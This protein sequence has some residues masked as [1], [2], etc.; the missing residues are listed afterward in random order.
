MGLIGAVEGIEV[1]FEEPTNGKDRRF[2]C[3]DVT[4][5]VVD[6]G[7]IGTELEETA[8]DGVVASTT[9]EFTSSSGLPGF[10]TNADPLLL[11]H[12]LLPNCNLRE[13][14]LPL[15]A[16]A[17]ASFFSFTSPPL[18]ASSS[19]TGGSSV[20]N[21]EGVGGA[22][23]VMLAIVP[24]SLES[25]TSE[26]VLVNVAALRFMNQLFL[27]LLPLEAAGTEERVV[28]A[29]TTTPIS[30][31]S[32]SSSS[33]GGA[34]VAIVGVLSPTI[35]SLLFPVPLLMLP[36][37]EDLV[38]S[39]LNVT[40]RCIPGSGGDE[41]S[42][43]EVLPTSERSLGESTWRSPMLGEDVELAGA[44]ESLRFREP[45][46][47]LSE[48]DR[49]TVSGALA[50]ILGK[51]RVTNTAKTLYLKKRKHKVSKKEEKKTG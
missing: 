35:S 16:A 6:G 19:E 34:K 40:C 28:A 49:A 22:E 25:S 1:V 44:G 11:F 13:I 31:T 15:F 2:C 5:F 27:F 3:L 46:M 14:R 18:P 42:P 30:E 48:D 9:S 23:L 29:L 45:A 12:D 51:T 32:F 33:S 37:A 43:V 39:K 50:A 26:P 7:G 17:A 36:V 8:D 41:T 47:A 4:E 38:C 20:T 21:V 24:A 10:S